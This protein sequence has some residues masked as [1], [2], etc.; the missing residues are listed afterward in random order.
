[1]IRH[2]FIAGCQDSLFL[3]VDFQVG[4]LKVINSWERIAGKVNQLIQTA[5]ILGIPILLTEQYKK[6]LGETHP[7][8]LREIKSPVICQKEHFSACMEPDFLSA[9]HSFRRNKIIVVGMEAHV[10]V[11]QTCLDLIKAGFQIHLVADAV[12]SRVKENR[13]IAIDIL[14]Q[15][16]A[17][18]TSTEI[19][20]FQWAYRANT[21]NFRKILP[22]VK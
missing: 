16:G 4:M 18:I 3:V 5:N 11:L 13:N 22:V 10:C 1:M 15:G 7:E 2:E 8:V 14:R 12:A 21:E 19:V 17:V 9:I 20:I 6:G